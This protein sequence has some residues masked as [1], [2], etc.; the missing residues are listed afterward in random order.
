M[1]HGLA[2]KPLLK[3]GALVTAANWEVVILQYLAEGAFKALLVLPLVAAAF[4]VAL[5][6]GGDV[7]DLADTPARQLI[8]LLVTALGAHP[9]ALVAWIAGVAVTVVG[10]AAIAFLVKGGTV[11]V[12]IAAERSAGAIEDRPLD[13]PVLRAAAGF[14]L[15]RFTEGCRR[16][17]RRYLALG[18][19]LIVIYGLLG[20]AYLATVYWTYTVVGETPLGAAWTFLAAVISSVFALVVMLVNLCYLL[21][22]VVVAVEDCAVRDAAAVVVRFVRAATRPVWAVFGVML[23]V[24]GLATVASVLATAGLGFIG[25]IPLVGLAVLPLQLLA[26]LARGLIF[27]SIG[28][29]A[30]CAYLRLYRGYRS[31]AALALVPEPA[32]LMGHTA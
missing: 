4:L 14:D 17:F 16:L 24:V 28:L 11:S 7:V 2:L 21:V 20:V 1:S 10:G 9:A 12:L 15:E 5:L 27:Q 23:I 3:R 25:F 30:L 6:V 22:Q 31:A 8:S 18:I 32:P 19:L 13:L 29:T 26:W